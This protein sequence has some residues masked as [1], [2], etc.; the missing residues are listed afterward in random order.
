MPWADVESDDGGSDFD[1]WHVVS[2]DDTD[3]GCSDA[4]ADVARSE[5]ERVHVVTVECGSYGRAN[6]L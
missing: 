2:D 6:E 1:W 3:D 5:H 4:S